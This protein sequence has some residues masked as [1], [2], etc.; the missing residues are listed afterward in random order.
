MIAAITSRPSRPPPDFIGN[1]T[2]PVPKPGN[3]IPPPPCPRRSST[4]PASVL[5]I[6][7]ILGGPPSIVALGYGPPWRDP[8]PTL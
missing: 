5:R 3:D 4:R 8:V 6:L 2:P 1:P 7:V